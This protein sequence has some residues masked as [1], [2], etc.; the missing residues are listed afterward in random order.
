V[1]WVLAVVILVFVA[2]SFLIPEKKAPPPKPA[3]P[4]DPFEA[5][6]PVPPMPGQTL[7]PSPRRSRELAGVVAEPAGGAEPDAAAHD[8]QEDD[9]D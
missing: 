9:R 6:Y 1:L 2:A 4:F 3:K 8:P 7:P 5:G